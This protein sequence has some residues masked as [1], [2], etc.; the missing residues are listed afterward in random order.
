MKELEDELNKISDDEEQDED[1]DEWIPKYKDCKCCYGFV[2]NCK[3]D[4]IDLVIFP[5]NS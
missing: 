2:Y 3:V 1:K 4:N 5:L